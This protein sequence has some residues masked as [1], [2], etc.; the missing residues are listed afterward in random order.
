MDELTGEELAEWEAY[1]RLEPIGEVREDYRKAYQAC[2]IANTT[3]RKKGSKPYE[4][5]DF[6]LT[7]G[8]R[9]FEKRKKMSISQIK[10]TLLDIFK[11]KLN[12]IQKMDKSKPARH[13]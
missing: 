4:V 6:L 13:Q 1:D 11:G 3:P 7:W 8:M 12:K 9:E 5:E 10:T 2:L